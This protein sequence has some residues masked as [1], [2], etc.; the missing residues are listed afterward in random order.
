[1]IPNPSTEIVAATTPAAAPTSAKAKKIAKI[2]GAAAF[3]FAMFGTLALPAYALNPATNVEAEIV[4]AST[5]Q[6]IKVSAGP[7]L[8][9]IDDIPLEVDTSIVEQEQRERAIAEAEAAAEAA[10]EQQ[11]AAT[12]AEPVAAVDVPAGQGAS[13][14]VNAALAQLGV[15][16]DCTA[17]VEKSLR[18][19]GHSVGDLAPAQF[20]AYGPSV[21]YSHGSTVLAPGDILI[22]GNAHVAIYVGGGKV[23]HGGWDGFT[24]VVAGLSTYHGLPTTVVRMS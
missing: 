1:M 13:G 6:T 21:G 24:T 18:A 17:L 4:Q 20:T 15:A 7:A 11:Q 12:K 10:A 14:I 22:W 5:A 8:T 16:Q 2:A 3:T 23:V 9:P 19:V